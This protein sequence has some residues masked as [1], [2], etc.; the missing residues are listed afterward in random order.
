M[1]PRCFIDYETR[2]ECS[3][4]SCGTWKYSLDP[5]T[6][7]LCL[8]FRMPYWPEGKTSLW[9][10]KFEHLG[11]AET[12]GVE[13]S[14]LGELFEWIEDGGLVEAHN[15]YFEKAHWQ[16]QCL[17]LGFPPIPQ[18]QIRCSAAKAAAHALPRALDDAIDA[19]DLPIRKDMDG[20]KLMRK[21]T[22]PRKPVKADIQTWN[23]RYAGCKEC[24]GKGKLK[25]GRAKAFP[26][27]VCSGRGYDD[28]IT[29]PPLPTL[30]HESR[31]LY[32]RLWAYC[33]QDVLA[34]EALSQALPDLNEDETS[35]Y[36]MDQVINERGFALDVEAV[37]VALE[38]IDLECV[39]LNAELAILTNGEVTK[40]TQ[41]AKMIEWFAGQGLALQDTQKETIAYWID[42]VKKRLD[43]NTEP[44]PAP[45][46]DDDDIPF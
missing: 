26:C 37:N 5:S 10:P 22:S 16:N 46:Y 21:L 42:I 44:T 6:E 45:V 20:H 18:S 40:A 25:V 28:R 19:L 9:H 1:E 3:L 38:L 8:G 24:H 36:A 41:R 29:I 17:R 34:E 4:R 27:P 33:R 35:Y 13:L 30:W 39:D 23:V 32:E 14:E 7:I 12:S 31:E 43:S 2:S 15:A 11:I